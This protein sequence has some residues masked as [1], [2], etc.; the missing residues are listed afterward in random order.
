M[1]SY[2]ESG[3]ATPVSCADVKKKKKNGFGES[4]SQFDCVSV[5]HL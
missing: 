2:V 4:E 3:D 5:Y 1:K